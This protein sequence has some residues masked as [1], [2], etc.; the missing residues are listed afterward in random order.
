MEE[1]GLEPTT[2]CFQNMVIHLFYEQCFQLMMH[3]KNIK[4]FIETY[5]LGLYLLFCQMKMI[6]R[7]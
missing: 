6:C 4:S 3:N 7:L 1:P 2:A 5:H